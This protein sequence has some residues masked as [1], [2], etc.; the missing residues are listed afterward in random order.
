M[1]FSKKYLIKP[2]WKTLCRPWQPT[3]AENAS[4]SDP[5]RHLFTI[6]LLYNWEEIKKIYRK[7]AR[8]SFQKA[9]INTRRS[10]WRLTALAGLR[11]TLAEQN[12]FIWMNEKFIERVLTVMSRPF[13]FDSKSENK[14][15]GI[16]FGICF[17]FL[18][19]EMRFENN[20]KKI[21]IDWKWF[22]VYESLFNETFLLFF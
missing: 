14:R 10:D 11:F 15:F 19:F 17:V 7:R 12:Q 1:N 5:V 13:V 3:R 9:S 20:C 16:E 6:L 18:T 2:N 22:T 8:K 21:P 4:E